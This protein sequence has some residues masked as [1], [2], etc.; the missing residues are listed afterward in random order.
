MQKSSLVSVAMTNA[1]MEDTMILTR[2]SKCIVEGIKER[3]KAQIFC[4]LK[5]ISYMRD[6]TFHL[7]RN[8]WNDVHEDWPFYTEQD[9][10]CLKR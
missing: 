8:I 10:A 9:R 4:I 2:V 1:V 6:N 7:N 3:E 5:T